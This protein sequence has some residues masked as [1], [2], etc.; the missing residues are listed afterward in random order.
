MKNLICKF[1]TIASKMKDVPLLALRLI[2]AYGFFDPGLKKLQNIESTTEWFKQIGMPAPELNVYLSGGIETVGAILI[3]L[4]L[5][6]RIMTIPMIITMVVAIVTV[7][8]GQGFNPSGGYE[9]P[10]YYIIML[11]TLTVFGSGRLSLDQLFTR[12]QK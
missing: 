9:I 7:H 11:F 10:V 6:T 8:W 12:K 2:L 1:N 5:G 3:A 4:G